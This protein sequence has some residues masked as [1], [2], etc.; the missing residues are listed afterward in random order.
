MLKKYFERKDGITY[1]YY[2]E[3]IEAGR[4]NVITSLTF[5]Y[6]FPEDFQPALKEIWDR[7]REIREFES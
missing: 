7:A 1:R 6:N 2:F 3:N 5:R 4:R